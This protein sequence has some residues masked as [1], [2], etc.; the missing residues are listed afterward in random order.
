MDCYCFTNIHV[1]HP[2]LPV[3]GDLEN[4]MGFYGEANAV[5]CPRE[6]TFQ[7][8]TAMATPDDSVPGPSPLVG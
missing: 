2:T 8:R 4:H 3:V 7:T 6:G 1:V 5:T